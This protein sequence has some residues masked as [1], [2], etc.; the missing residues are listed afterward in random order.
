MTAFAPIASPP[1]PLLGR[2]IESKIR[3][4]LHEYEMIQKGETISVALSGG[5]DSLALLYFLHALRGRGLPFFDLIAI[6]VKGRFSCGAG[7]SVPFLERICQALK[8]PFFIEESF[9]KEESLECY[10]C[11]RERRK[12]LFEKAKKEGSCKIAF[13]HHFDDSN[14]TLLLNLLHKAE[15]EPIQP[16]I[17]M[18]NFGV[19]VLRPLIFVEE[20]K[21]IRF[22]QHY[23]FQR[24]TCQCP[25]GQNSH[26]KKTKDL[27]KKLEEVFPNTSQNLFLAG[28]KLN[29][30][31]ALIPS[32]RKEI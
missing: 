28:K 26:R 25:Y 23:G 3:K 32:L 9:L 15:F 8:I 22:A 30:G 19:T 7:V 5:K 4:A 31:K 13:G 12:L 1:W 24:V 18:Y 6:H 29:R 10:S 27:I 21:L 11:S 17:F 16:K 14:Q 2:Q 20:E